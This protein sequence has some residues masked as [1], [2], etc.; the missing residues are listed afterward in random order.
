MKPFFLFVLL[1]LPAMAVPESLYNMRP[2]RDYMSFAGGKYLEWHQKNFQ[3]PALTPLEKEL[4]SHLTH[5]VVPETEARSQLLVCHRE[6]KGDGILQTLR[7]WISPELRKNKEFSVVAGFTPEFYERTSDGRI[8]L[9]S[10]EAWCRKPGMKKWELRHR[11]KVVTGHLPWNN[12]FPLLSQ[13]EVRFSDPEG[14]VIAIAYYRGISHVS[15]IPPSL[16]MIVRAH[17]LDTAFGMD[18]YILEKDGTMSACYP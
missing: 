9:I 15:L 14:N 3:F 2:D 11:E 8:C 13:D 16:L 5:W 12:R 10:G 17:S 4:V 6:D 18:R 1:S 7:L